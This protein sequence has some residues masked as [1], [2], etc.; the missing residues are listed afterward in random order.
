MAFL[1]GIFGVVGRFAGRLLTTTLGWA[2][3]L[4]FG[5]V[6][7]SRQI[8]LALITFGSV[9]WAALVIGIVLPDLGAFLVAVVP[10]PDLVDRGWI[11]LAMLI[12][13]LIVPAVVGGATIFVLDPADRPSGRA[14]VDQVVRGY[15]LCAA[16]AV[17][18]VILAG[19]GIARFVHHRAIGWVDAHVPIV[20]HPGGYE[21]VV[22]DLERALDDA[23]L[24]VERRPAPLPLAIPGR[25]LGRIAGPGIRSLVP[26]RPVELIGQDLEIGLYPSDI[27]IGGKKLIVARARAAIST[28]L[29]STAASMT[30]SAEAQAVEAMLERLTKARV[31][32]A[33]PGGGAAV[34]LA[35]AAST[36]AAVD[37]RLASLDVPHD[38]W[39]ILYRQRLQVER[40][41]LAGRAPGSVL[42][43]DRGTPLAASIDFAAARAADPRRRAGWSNVVAAAGLV[44]I[45]ADVAMALLERDRRRR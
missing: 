5:R 4:L 9:I 21:R 20:V 38:E 33:E 30:T 26:G 11:R 29:T 16:L 28:R 18:M 37:Q 1:A 6:P 8:V 23:G 15:P 43:T 39:E 34:D 19:V 27:S 45:A 17:T 42:T 7:Q 25:M 3:S 14:L 2:S 32:G 22:A 35:M 13:A 31:A 12:G 10:A 40:D 44:L 41:L 24:D 36:L